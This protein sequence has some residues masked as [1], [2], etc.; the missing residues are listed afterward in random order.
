MN[1]SDGYLCCGGRSGG[2]PPALATSPPRARS[3]TGGKRPRSSTSCRTPGPATS[4][5]SWPP[6]TSSPTKSRLLINVGDEKGALLDAAVRRADPALALELGT[7]CGYGALRIARAAPDGQGVLGRTRRGQRRQRPPDLGARR[8][9]RPGDVRGRHHRRRRAHPGRA[10]RRAR[11]RLRRTGFR[12]PRPRQGRLP[13]RP[14]EHPGPGLAAPG[15]DRG[16]RQR[17]GARARRS[18]ASTCVSS[19]ASCGTPS[20]TRRTW[21]TRRWCPTWCWSRSTWAER[22]ERRRY[23]ARGGLRPTLRAARAR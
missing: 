6:S 14:A 13:G 2:W 5:T 8:R 18:T 12:V 3:V 22:A 1:S 10:G 11:V 7:Y 4:T 19:R 15:L 21:S 9:R 20:S 17:P 16:R 23:C